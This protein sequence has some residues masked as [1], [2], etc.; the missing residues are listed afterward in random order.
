MLETRQTR[1]GAVES[2]PAAAAA[3]P[4][5]AA[6]PTGL[7]AAT[8]TSAPLPAGMLATPRRKTLAL[9]LTVLLAALIGVL[10]IGARYLLFGAGGEASA[11]PPLALPGQ[12]APLR[13]VFAINGVQRPLGVAVAAAGDR[14]YVTESDGERQLKIFDRDGNLLRAVAPPET[15]TAGR[16][17]VY[18]AAHRAGKVYVTDRTRGTVDVYSRDGD[19]EGELEPPA[20]I[21]RPWAPLGI[22]VSPEGDIALTEVTKGRHRVLLLRPD[23]TLRLSFGQEGSGVGELNYPNAIAFDR[24]GRIFVADSNNGRVAAF[25]GEGRPLWAFSRGSS[26]TLALPRGL[27]I[28][29]ENRLYVV[30]AVSHNVLGFALGAQS[31]Q[32]VFT[33]G[34]LGQDNG[35][36][37][38][39]NGL[40]VDGTGRIYVADR[41]NH[42][43][44]VWTN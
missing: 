44:Q 10:G 1:R 15:A 32:P 36:F 17:P 39:P 20:E 23:G 21:G 31:A 16:A 42:R 26:G 9:V 40:A 28:D 25:D 7:I 14:L 11:L 34:T 13:F 8:G 3:G 27:A 12:T 22:A 35:Q 30:D 43:V 2:P 19:Y 4:Q 33:L 29:R 6:P 5:H 18:V 38:F 41:E 37:T 24:A